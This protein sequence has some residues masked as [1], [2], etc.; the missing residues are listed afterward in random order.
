MNEIE[1]TEK[2]IGWGLAIFWALGSLWLLLQPLPSHANE[3]EIATKSPQSVYGWIYNTKTKTLQLCTQMGGQTYDPMSKVICLE[4][5][6]KVK[7]LSEFEEFTT[8]GV[9]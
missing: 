7:H 2:I 6:K 5:P 9:K 3:D 4:Y 8:G 1:K